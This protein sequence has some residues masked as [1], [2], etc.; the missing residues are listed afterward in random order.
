[1]DRRN[2][3]KACGLT[4]ASLLIN[5]NVFAE[6]TTQWKRTPHIKPVVCSCFEFHHPSIPEGKYWND[7]LTNFTEAQ[8]KAKVKEIAE[9]G[10]QYLVLNN[11]ANFG[12]TYY[13][14]KIQPR[15]DEYVCSDPLEAVLAAADECGVKFFVSN[16]FWGNWAQTRNLMID[17]E[18]AKIR[19]A[20]MEEMAEKY[21][22]HKSFYGWYY[23][24]ESG[25]HNG[26]DDIT[27]NYCNQCN[28]VAKE[29]MPH[30][31]NM[32]SPYGTMSVRLD[33]NYV[34]QLE[35][36]DIDIVSYQDEV[37]VK[38][39]KA[40]YA[41]KYFEG[42][43]QAHAKAGR[44]RLWADV[45]FFEFE[46]PV[47]RSALLPADFSRILKQMEDVSPYAEHIM[48]YDYI[49][50]MNKPGSLAFAGHPS[51]VK[52]YTDYVNWLKAQQ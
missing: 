26:I 25:L 20:A 32:L 49:G 11:V 9:I 30:S 19:F 46:G 39:T 18:V 4:S 14:S 40:G 47:Y 6:E 8:W 28:H 48:I 7:S 34:R 2:F 43:Y 41:G 31:V 5:D 15:H 10:I 37:G 45:E 52:L 35:K 16:G 27:M 3:I 24:N 17:K 33:D 23:P 36:L 51:S 13:P 44:S 12:K 42:L 22:H 21:G 38:K 1:M 50:M 29:L